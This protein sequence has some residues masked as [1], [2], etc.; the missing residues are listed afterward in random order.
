MPMSDL[1]YHKFRLWCESGLF[2]LLLRLVNTD[3]QT[4]TL[5]EIDSTFCKVH[6]PH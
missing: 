2:E 4:T 6:A 3:A 1:L 5:L